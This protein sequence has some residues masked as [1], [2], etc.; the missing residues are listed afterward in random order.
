LE[1]S[2]HSGP[3]SRPQGPRNGTLD[4]L[5]RPAAP[6]HDLDRFSAWL[7]RRQLAG[8]LQRPHFVRWV[9][10]FLR[11]ART[12]PHEAWTDTLTVFLEDLGAAH[13][14]PWQVRQA[15]QAAS[16]YCEQFRRLERDGRLAEAASSTADSHPPR[17]QHDHS[18]PAPSAASPGPNGLDSAS[19]TPHVALFDAPAALAELSRILHLRH[20]S[21]RTY[22]A[23]VG[24]ARR[25]LRYVGGQHRGDP[26]TADAKAF[27]SRLA[28]RQR[29][30][31]ST[32]N[33]A[34]HALL[35]LHRHVLRADLGDLGTTVRAQRGQRLPVVLTIDEVRAVLSHLRGG[36]R[37]MLELVYGAGLRLTDV[38][39]LRVKDIDFASGSIT[40]R[41]G[42]GEKDR[43][44]LLP[45][46]AVPALETHLRRRRQI[47]D[48]DLASGAGEAPLPSALDRKYPRAGR[49]WGWQFVFPSAVLHSDPDSHRVYRW[50]VSPATVQRAMKVA[51]QRAGIAKPASVHTLRHSFAT[52]LLMKGTDIRRIQELLG[53]KDVKTTMIY[54]HV[55]QAIA[56]NV[57]SPLDEL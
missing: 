23:Y 53:H 27:L 57:T 36:H 41:C 22:R 17:G 6:G 25:Y 39:T 34:F 4:K 44:T 7:M 33:Q 21:P 14:P 37:L 29:V 30:A 24:W 31:G 56:P 11:L 46:R 8:R 16:L 52:H 3:D 49:E 28:T 40:I 47:H 13:T 9:R 15:A 1:V 18:L 26:C 48:R 19:R 2:Q 55:M 5:E 20:Y 32:Q 51:V 38:I 54:T 50:H 10:R 45:R 42:K 43:V 35:F 12:R